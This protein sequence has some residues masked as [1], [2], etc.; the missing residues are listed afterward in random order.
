M[1]GD[2]LNR[3]LIMRIR[4]L[5]RQEWTGGGALESSVMN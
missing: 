4:R 5:T 1:H 3:L 2:R